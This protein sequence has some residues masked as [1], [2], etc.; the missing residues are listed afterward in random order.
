VT[1]RGGRTQPCDRTPA[2]MRL[3]NAQ[4]SLEV[5]EL[6]AAEQEIPASR[7]VAAALAVL[8]GIASADAAC[9]AALGRRSRGED[10]REAAALLRQIVPDGNRAATAL[11]ELLNLKDTAQYGLIPIT[12][13]ELTVALRRA[14]RLLELAGDVLRR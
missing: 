4:K 7:S 3:D 1:R 12:Q 14:K 10:H 6:A 11:I 9:C 13:R 8:S 5:A 2:R